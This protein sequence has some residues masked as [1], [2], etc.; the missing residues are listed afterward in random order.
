MKNKKRLSKK[1]IRLIVVLSVAAA[2]FISLII[3]NVFI[4]VKY[5]GAYINFLK[6]LPPQNG[7]RIRYLNVEF[8]DCALI[9]F[10]DGKSMLV[11]G[12]TGTYSNAHKLLKILNSSGINKLDYLVCTSVKSEHCGG[13]TEIVKYKP[14]GK[15]FLPDVKNKRLTDEYNA[16]ISAVS[17]SGAETETAVYGNGGYNEEKGYGFFFLSPSFE[18]ART[19]YDEM[20][21]SPTSENINA[22]SAVMWLECSGYG[23]MFL[24]DCT[25]DVQKKI[26]RIFLAEGG[27][28]VFKGM[29]ITL[30]GCAVLKA[31]GHCGKETVSA[32][33]CE[34]VNPSAAVISVGRNAQNC[35]WAEDL[36]VLQLYVKN[37]V[38]R[39][40]VNGEVTVTVS[41]GKY[42]LAKEFE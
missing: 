15:V 14:V 13:L 18:G 8:G 20:N 10:P 4:P 2:V 19:E 3:T 28:Y 1:I 29:E 21:D 38:L 35:P 17:E 36:A 16:F 11:D 25:A 5:L 33:L 40:D 30:S 41:D 6:D 22:A 12:G 7:L 42:G 39:T 23:F 32:E 34:A 26:S 31:A 27:K 9:E 24:S 37:S